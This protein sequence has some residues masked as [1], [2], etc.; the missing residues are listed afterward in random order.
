MQ[1]ALWCQVCLG[2]LLRQ[3][4]T[5]A[6]WGAAVVFVLRAAR[7][8]SKPE[9]LGRGED[10]SQVIRSQAQAETAQPIA[11]Y[12]TCETCRACSASSTCEARGMSPSGVRPSGPASMSDACLFAA[13]EAY[14]SAFASRRL[15]SVSIQEWR[16][17]GANRTAPLKGHCDAQDHLLSAGQERAG[18]TGPGPCQAVAGVTSAAWLSR[19]AASCGARVESTA[20]RQTSSSMPRAIAGSKREVAG[21]SVLFHWSLLRRSALVA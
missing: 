3:T 14:A 15:G 10:L 2:P 20:K 6:P 21:D 5:A 7:F 18:S 12:A 11:P 1:P 16:T 19:P 17:V 8:G 9:P 4:T 13:A